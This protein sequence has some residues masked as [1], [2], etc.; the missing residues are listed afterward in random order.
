MHLLC[1]KILFE[2][3]KDTKDDHK[4]QM[5]I[6]KY[7][8]FWTNIHFGAL[9][10]FCET[11]TLCNFWAMSDRNAFVALKTCAFIHFAGWNF[12]RL[13]RR[14]KEPEQ[15]SNVNFK[16]IS[17]FPT[18]WTNLFI[19]DHC[20]GSGKQQHHAIFE[21]HLIAKY[22]FNSIIFFGFNFLTKKI[23]LP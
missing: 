6:L 14:Y 16:E 15:Y 22:L 21:Q 20:S 7:P 18:F 12:Q 10:R 5:S 8:T 17:I 9:C 11:A 19:L 2:Y 3:L 4:V 13:A 23:W 1:S